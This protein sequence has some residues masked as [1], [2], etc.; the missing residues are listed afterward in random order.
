MP[1]PAEPESTHSQQSTESF[2]L[3]QGGWHFRAKLISM[4]TGCA[5]FLLILID[6]L[7]PR[8][9]AG[10]SL[11]GE[12]SEF[13]EFL[14]LC[15][16]LAILALLA[17]QYIYQREFELKRR[18]ERLEARRFVALGR[19]AG[20]IAHE[21]RNP[22]QN[23]H[24][25]IEELRSSVPVEDQEL[26]VHMESNI[27]RIN[28]AVKLVYELAKPSSQMYEDLANNINLKQLADEVS[29]R[30]RSQFEVAIHTDDI[31]K[32]MTVSAHRSALVLTLENILRNAC[33]YCLSHDDSEGINIRSLSNNTHFGLQVINKGSLPKHLMDNS[34]AAPTEKKD[35]LG[36]GLFIARH[37][38]ER[39][40]G[41]LAIEQ[42]ND[43]V[44]VSI[45]LPK[46]VIYDL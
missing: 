20:S 42:E 1:D 16:G 27:A 8:Y 21:V 38:L 26:L 3:G 10:Q 31:D 22:L 15:P 36:L 29:E 35:G 41:E 37:L 11:F 6:D 30:N 9:Q 19:I 4:L 7:I 18:I 34:I 43:T 28:M 44:I 24:L 23:L 25:A 32:N 12:V 5:G 39:M 46:G 45:L 40:N 2:S 33:Q 13:I 17:A 14:V